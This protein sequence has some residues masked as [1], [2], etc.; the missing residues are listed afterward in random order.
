MGPDN[1]SI[2]TNNSNNNTTLEESKSSKS[3]RRKD[4]IESLK[5]SVAAIVIQK[6]IRGSIYRGYAVKK[7]IEKMIADSKISEKDNVKETIN[8]KDSN[9]SNIINNITNDDDDNDENE[10]LDNDERNIIADSIAA[11]ER[12]ANNINEKVKWPEP[13]R[14]NFDER[15]KR[16]NLDFID[17]NV[18]TIE[19]WILENKKVLIRLITWNLC[20]RNPPA[21]D[22]I[23]RTLIPKN[24]FHFYVIGTEE[25]ERSIAQS[26]INT[27]KKKW[28]AYLQE[29]LGENYIPLRSHTLQ[30]THV[31]VFGHKAVAHLCSSFTS[32]AVATGIGNTLGNKGG[33]LVSFKIGNSSFAFVNAHLAAHQNAVKERNQNYHNI[34]KGL[35]QFLDKKNRVGSNVASSLD[36][37]NLADRSASTSVNSSLDAT[38]SNS[39]ISQE[40]IDNDRS[41]PAILNKKESLTLDQCADRVFFMGDLNYRIRG[42]YAAVLK[43]LELNMIEVMLHND[44]LTWSMA[45][46][47]VLD[48]FVEPTICF[49]PT[50]KLDLNSDKY[51]SS[52]KKRIPAWTDRVL[53]VPNG[54]T[55]T[56][57]DAD[58][59]LKTSDHRPVYASFEAHVDITNSHVIDE[60][61]LR[62]SQSS[63]HEFVSESQVCS[64]Q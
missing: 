40:N 55:C 46:S 22:E 33:V 34:S 52:T 2:K 7:R 39:N 5:K 13:F 53:Y 38:I 54:I 24:K 6:R 15:L 61:G 28:E 45:N 51:D 60:N 17:K 8:V 20:A 4:R 29:C 30:A 11:E 35:A 23:T 41:S 1:N 42:N 9:D 48:N 56:A 47:L 10:E 32:S 18:E 63:N 25:C 14:D 62:T 27:S 49:K 19:S 58:F 26:A 59:S 12:E 3:I 16:P 50:Y 21:V 36:S 44:Q 64:I 37:S 57:Y 43:L 31:I